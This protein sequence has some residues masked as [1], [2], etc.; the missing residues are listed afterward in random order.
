MFWCCGT[1]GNRVREAPF[2]STKALGAHF[3]K[4][5]AGE[6]TRDGP[7]GANSYFCPSLTIVSDKTLTPPGLRFP[8]N[9]TVGG[10]SIGVATAMFDA[11][12]CSHIVV[13]LRRENGNSTDEVGFCW[14]TFLSLAGERR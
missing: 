14:R 9:P 13:E 1:T 12:G 10:G 3:G 8:G 2:D 7:A 6:G 4:C 5:V 11:L